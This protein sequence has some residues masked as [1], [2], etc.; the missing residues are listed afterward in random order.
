MKTAQEHFNLLDAWVT[1]LPKNLAAH[2]PLYPTPTRQLI[3]Q[4]ATTTCR[5]ARRRILAKLRD[6][7]CPIF[8]VPAFSGIKKYEQWLAS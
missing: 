6:A 7:I 3:N 2:T 8:S 1:T 5:D 4:L